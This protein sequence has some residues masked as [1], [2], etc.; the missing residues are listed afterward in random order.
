LIIFILGLLCISIIYPFWNLIVI[1]FNTSIDTARGGLT[2]FPREFTF[3]NYANVFVDKRLVNAFIITVLRTV[4]TTVGCTLFTG[5]FAYGISRKELKFR[6]AYT[7]FCAITMYLTAGLIPTY[8]LMQKLNL[9]NSFWVMV[10]PY[11]FS[12]WNMIIFRSFFDGLPPSLIEAAR[13]DGAGEY[14][15]FFKIVMP[16]SKPVFA[17]LALFTAVAQWNAWFDGAIYI[18]DPNLMPLPTLLRQIINSNSATQLM[19]QLS[20]T[21]AD[22]MADKMISTRSLS[23]ATM[24][25][26]IIPI[27]A[28]YPFI[29]KYFASGVT[30]GS[31]KE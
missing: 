24:I 6:K 28:V 22:Q 3:E 25:V 4:I 2:F 21:A 23:S 15:V 18:T 20:S 19:A 16:V 8:I 29:Q 5:V 7:K 11:L 17:T 26:S 1:S 13:M 31:V 30:V 9:I 10:I 27:I 14:W 12:V